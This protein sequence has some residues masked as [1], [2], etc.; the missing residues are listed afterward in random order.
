MLRQSPPHEAL[1]V[2]ALADALALAYL[3]ILT[4]SG[5]FLRIQPLFW[6]DVQGRLVSGKCTGSLD[7]LM[8][9]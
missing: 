1:L 3:A 6:L 4:Y 8:A 2:F 5:S 9:L 7:K